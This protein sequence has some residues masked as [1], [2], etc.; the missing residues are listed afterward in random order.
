L[1]K[2]GIIKLSAVCY[3]INLVLFDLY[4]F[5]QTMKDS[6]FLELIIVDFGLTDED[7]SLDPLHEV[8]RHQSMIMNDPSL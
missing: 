7:G 2:F 6:S 3:Y 1:I 4:G 5:L 8:M